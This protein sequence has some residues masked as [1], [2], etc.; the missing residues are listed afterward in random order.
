MALIKFIE[1]GNARVAMQIY[2]K[3]LKMKSYY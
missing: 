1:L 3:S 2:L